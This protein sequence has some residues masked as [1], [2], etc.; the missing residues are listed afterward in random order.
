MTAVQWLVKELGL[1]MSD[2]V[3]TALDIEKYH[4]E[5]AFQIGEWNENAYQNTGHRIHKNEKDYYNKT[6]KS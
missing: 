6:Y 2:A 3:E 5:H 1:E 4:L